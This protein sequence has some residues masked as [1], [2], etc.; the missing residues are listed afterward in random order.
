MP[1]L[2]F[3]WERELEI[4]KFKPKKVYHPSFTLTHQDSSLGPFTLNDPKIHIY[5]EN[6]SDYKIIFNTNN[7]EIN[8]INI[9]NSTH[10]RPLA[11]NTVAMLKIASDFLHI[12]PNQAMHIAERL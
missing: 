10:K 12:S 6:Y 8:N 3:V 7:I 4:S 5:D 9:S 2:H 11:L 1:T